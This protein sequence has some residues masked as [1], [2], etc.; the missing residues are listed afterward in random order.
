MENMNTQDVQSSMQQPRPVQ[1]FA[2]VAAQPT[3]TQVPP[4][5]I[6]QQV[7]PQTT[8]AN[9]LMRHFR[10]PSLNIKLV[11]NGRFWKDGALDLPISGEIPIYP[12]TAKDEIILKTPDSLV[13]GASVVQVIQSCCP[14]IK[15]A[16]A[17]PSIDVDYT[18]VAIRIASYGQMMHI[19]AKCPH[20]DE[21]HDYDIDLHNIL[22]QIQTPNYAE[23]IVVNDNLAIR[24]KPLTYGEV[25][26]AGSTS[27]EEERLLKA[28]NDPEVDDDTKSS[29][30][31]KHVAKMIES[32]VDNA[33]ACTDSIVADGV[34]VVD[35]KFIKEFYQNTE[36]STMRKIHAKIAEFSD[37]VSI[38]SQPTLCT[39]CDKEFKL[40]IEFDYS[41]FFGNGS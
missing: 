4:Q 28:L 27:L 22:G 37:I 30:Y 21:E 25:S 17:M 39:A 10:H 1:E 6:R 41:R 3:F 14:N 20:C 9:P 18:L 8:I 13:S 2:P 7:Q 35:K 36:S 5:P 29:A 19:S 32:N 15:D 40:G 26:K 33:T 34:E 24:L 16:W 38:K 23:A 31:S 11:S 12:M